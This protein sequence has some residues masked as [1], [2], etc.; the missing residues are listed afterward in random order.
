MDKKRCSKCKQ[1]K[2][3]SEFYK[4]RKDGHLYNYQ[5]KTCQDIYRKTHQ[6][7]I[8]KQAKKRYQVN[9]NE[10]LEGMKEK[11]KLPRIK[12]QSR[13]CRIKYKYGITADEH[14]Q[15]YID[16]N[17]QCAICE[18]PTAYDRVCTDHDHQTG[19]VR[20][21]LCRHC[22]LWMAAIDSKDFLEKAIEYQKRGLLHAD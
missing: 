18:I 15:M 12:E 3:L 14:K 20:G 5:C 22:N 16:Q 6:V 11:R 13:V 17:G 7:K 4:R 8:I 10:I 2:P 19:K 9:K 1:E 21:L